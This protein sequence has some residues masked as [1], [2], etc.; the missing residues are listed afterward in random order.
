M[1]QPLVRM[2]MKATNAAGIKAVKDAAV[3]ADH[4]KAAAQGCE[5]SGDLSAKMSSAEVVAGKLGQAKK[6]LAK[7]SGGGFN[8]LLV[9]NALKE[10]HPVWEPV[11]DSE[12]CRSS[13]LEALS[14]FHTKMDEAC[15]KAAAGDGDKAKRIEKLTEI[16][17]DADKAQEALASLSKGL[18]IQQFS[19]LIAHATV[20]GYLSSIE[21]ELGK[22]ENMNPAELLKDT[23][24]LGK[25][26]PSLGGSS[27]DTCKERWSDLHGQIKTRMLESME[28][29]CAKANDKKKQGLLKFAEGFDTACGSFSDGLLADELKAK[30]ES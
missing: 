22:T 14:A 12:A 11:K 26:W 1:E 7:P 3:T 25:A 9:V 4:A 18:E 10:L 20:D 27:L 30:M 29:A 15:K 5:A 2:M 6:E 17:S 23:Q 8:P 28:D 16:A 19:W 21:A 13:L 24:A